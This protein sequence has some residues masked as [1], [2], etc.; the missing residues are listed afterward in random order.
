MIYDRK[1]QINV[2]VSEVVTIKSLRLLLDSDNNTKTKPTGHKLLSKSALR[3]VPP[4]NECFGELLWT[5]E[6]V[7]RVQ[8]I[9]QY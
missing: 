5:H 8:M 2:H 4:L 6:R 3:H 1:R 9:T 7:Y